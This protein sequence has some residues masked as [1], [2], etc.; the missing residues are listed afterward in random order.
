MSTPDVRGTDLLAHTTLHIGE[1]PTPWTVTQMI[2]A[3]QRVPG[4]LV[5]ELDGARV[6][7]IVAHDS[8]VPE[9][10]LIAAAARAGV[11]ATI[12]ATAETPAIGVSSTSPVKARTTR[13]RVIGAATAFV[14]L[15]VLNALLSSSAQNHWL[16]TVLLLTTWVLL[17]ASLIVRKKA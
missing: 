11:T 17:F 16:L 2:H 5:A 7:A 4:V 6:R 3:L 15:T 9:A 12:V 13:R 8:A 14:G 1:D 10:S